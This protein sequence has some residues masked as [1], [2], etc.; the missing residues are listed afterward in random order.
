MEAAWKRERLPQAGSQRVA[1][2]EAA[3]G[4]AREGWLAAG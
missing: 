3:K 4:R 1:A 2:E